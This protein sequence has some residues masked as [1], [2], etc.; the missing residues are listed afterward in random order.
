[1]EDATIIQPL[2]ALLI[3]SLTTE[4]IAN[5]I[6]LWKWF[7]VS[8]ELTGAA[9]ETALEKRAQ[10]IS[11]SVGVAIALVA[12]ADLFVLFTDSNFTF[13]WDNPPRGVLKWVSA[14]TGSVLAGGFLSLGSQFF[15][16]LLAILFQVK[17]AKS[18]LNSLSKVE[19]A[20]DLQ[21]ITD[22]A[23]SNPTR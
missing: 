6:K 13:F 19:N 11:F 1:M 21:K 18:K 8:A 3:L 12:K 4:K 9:R 16:D 20:G 23:N 7:P 17:S 10:Y 22:E 2:V 15:H 5:I 14:V